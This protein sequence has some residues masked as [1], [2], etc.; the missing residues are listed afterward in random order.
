MR[1]QAELK[2]FLVARVARQKKYRLKKRLCAVSGEVI[3]CS[4][5]GT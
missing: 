2:R 5:D 3:V 4:W 1:G